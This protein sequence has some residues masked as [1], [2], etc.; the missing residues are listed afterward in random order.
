MQ[1]Y[2]ARMPY[3]YLLPLSRQ[4]SVIIIVYQR[5]LKKQLQIFRTSKVV[6]H[7]YSL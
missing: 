7:V 2:N 4:L 3:V 1:Y 5:N 6:L